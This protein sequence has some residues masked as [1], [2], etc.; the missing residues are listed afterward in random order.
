M[1]FAM[2][3]YSFLLTVLLFVAGSQSCSLPPGTPSLSVTGRTVLAPNV[4]HGRVLNISTTTR[5]N[6]FY[7]ACVQV[8]EVIKG[9]SNIP[10]TFCFGDFGGEY[11]CL[12]DVF[13][14]KEYIFFLNEDLTARYKDGIPVSAILA[15]SPLIV[16]MAKEGYCDPYGSQSK[17]C[18]RYIKVLIHRE[19]WTH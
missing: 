6:V 19:L 4:I 8:L 1:V 3:I 5:L 14:Q 12:T 16:E 15:S 7:K 18:G 10:S 11:L 9:D 2:T 17:R 13:E